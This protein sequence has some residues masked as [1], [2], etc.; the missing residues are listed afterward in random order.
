MVIYN[1]AIEKTSPATN[2]LDWW[3][4]VQREVTAV[5]A[6]DTNK[7]AGAIID[8]WHHNW[9]NVGDTPT[10][11]AGRIRRAAARLISCPHM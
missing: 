1:E 5:V 2:G 8:W 4:Q 10:R 7:N 3:L 6:A 9:R 11:A